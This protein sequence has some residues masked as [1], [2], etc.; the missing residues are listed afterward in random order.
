MLKEHQNLLLSQS[1]VCFVEQAC[2]LL[3][4][5]GTNGLVRSFVRSLVI[6]V[7]H[8]PQSDHVRNTRVERAVCKRRSAW[9]GSL[10][11]GAVLVTV[12]LQKS[13]IYGGKK[14]EKK[15]NKFL[16]VDLKNQF[17]TI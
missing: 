2:A 14:K 15:I 16:C 4:G 7:V 11:G 13:I 8:S 17:L 10:W 5:C 3:Q 12:L 9:S 6:I 1:F